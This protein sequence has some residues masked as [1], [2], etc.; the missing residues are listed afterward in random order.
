MQPLSAPAAL[1]AYFPGSR[2]TNNALLDGQTSPASYPAGNLFRPTAEA[3]FMNLA[4]GDYRLG[5]ASPF[6]ASGTDGRAIGADVATLMSMI[7]NTVTGRTAA[8]CRL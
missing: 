4:A 1:N 7:A 8:F 3:G 2:F 5:A 6:L